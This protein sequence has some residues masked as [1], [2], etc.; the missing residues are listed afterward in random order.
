[1]VMGWPMAVT[2]MRP[3]LSAGV[4]P[5]ANTGNFNFSSAHKS[6]VQVLITAPRT[7]LAMQA[8][9]SSSPQNAQSK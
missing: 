4:V 7:P 9:E 1:M 2:S 8:V 3:L 5:M 6:R